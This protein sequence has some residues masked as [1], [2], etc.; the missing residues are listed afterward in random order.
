MYRYSW[1]KS[2]SIPPPQYA[3]D[4]DADA[5]AAGRST[6]AA[7]AGQHALRQDEEPHAASNVRA[8]FL[9]TVKEM[10]RLSTLN[11]SLWNKQTVISACVFSRRGSG[12]MEEDEEP[13]VEDVMMSS[14]DRLEDINEGMDFDTMD[15]DLVCWYNSRMINDNNSTWHFYWYVMIKRKKFYTVFPFCLCLLRYV[16]LKWTDCLF[17]SRHQR[18]AEKE[19]NWSQTT[20]IRLPSWTIQ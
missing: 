12:L 5:E 6:P 9:F 2:V 20:L 14:E 10:R 11:D 19:L 15:I 7:G 16:E 8:G 4:L 1:V 17:F 3:G 13:I 18:T